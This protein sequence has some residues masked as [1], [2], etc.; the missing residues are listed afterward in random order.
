MVTPH[1]SVPLRILL[2][3]P[4]PTVLVAMNQALHQLREPWEAELVST[5][6]ELLA[7]MA[8]KPIDILVTEINLP[9]M[10]GLDLLT[11]VKSCFPKTVRIIHTQQ[12]DTAEMVKIVPEAHQS[13]VKPFEPVA[14]VSAIERTQTLRTLLA[15]EDL[16]KLVSRLERLPS[17]PLVY[18]QVVRELKNREPSMR[19]VGELIAQDVAMSTKVLRLVNSAFFGLQQEV[20]NPAHAVNLLGLEMIRSLVLAVGIFSHYDTPAFAFLQKA[21]DDL[22]QHSLRVSNNVR[23]IAGLENWPQ[24]RTD[25]FA[26]AGLVHDVGK[27]VLMTNLPTAYQVVQKM[28]LDEGIAQTEAEDAVLGATHA[29]VGAYMLGLWGFSADILDACVHDHIPLSLPC[30]VDGTFVVRLANLLDHGIQSGQTAQDWYQAHR[31]EFAPTDM[32]D[33]LV[34]WY[35]ERLIRWYTLCQ[36][37]AKER[38]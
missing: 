18:F 27:L 25:E 23:L 24:R 38:D 4:D 8:A 2:A 29:E 16:V 26:I 22:Q 36:Q 14:L 3:D 11:E 31:Q 32:E 12:V 19:R 9:D 30:P 7:R 13:L 34:Q 28:V 33:R 21:L 35:E 10:G 1:A 37:K 20:T 17:P 6:Q 5:G 15:N